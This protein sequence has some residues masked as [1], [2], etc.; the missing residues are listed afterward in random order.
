MNRRHL[1]L[2]AGLALCLLGMGGDRFRYTR[3]VNAAPGANVLELPLDVLSAAAPGLADVRLR[4][5]HGELPLSLEAPAESGQR[6][7]LIDVEAAP[8]RETQA[9]LDRGENPGL[10]SGL[11]LLVE[12]TQAFL[13]PLVVEA[14]DDRQSF[15]VLA[16]TSIFRTEGGSSLE[17][18]F[19][20]SDRRYLRLRF[21][22][23][24]SPPIQPLAAELAPAPRAA[25]PERRLSLAFRA[26]PDEADD[27][28]RYTAVLPGKNLPAVRLELD[29]RGASLAREVRVYERLP[30]RGELSRRL[31]AATAVE[32][33]GAAGVRS[34]A[35]GGLG[36][37]ELELELERAGAPLELA[38][39]TLVWEPVRVVFVAPP[40]SGL[41]LAYGS[42]GAPPATRDAARA[43]APLRDGE[44]FEAT[45]GPVIDHGPQRAFA[46]VERSPLPDAAEY[47][48][49]RA[50]TL[51]AEGELAY[52]DLTGLAP[53]AAASL[54]LLDGSGRQVPFVVEQPARRAR[55]PLRSSV[56]SQ[57][58][59][60]TLTLTGFDP[61]EHVVGLELVTRSPAPFARAVRVYELTRDQRGPTGRRLL[62]SGHWQRASEQAE[63]RLGVSISRPS[64]TEGELVVEIDDGDNAPLASLGGSALVARARIDF[65]FEPGDRL[66][67]LAD[68]PR[69]TPA[70]YDLALLADR[71]QRA[72]ALPA[73]LA[74]LTRA[75]PTE[76]PASERR[77]LW[78]WAVFVAAGALVVLTLTRVLRPDAR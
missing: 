28:D 7:S 9:L 26:A 30:F 49:R 70:R 24:L 23:R 57:P 56:A 48:Q 53:E 20:P 55:V 16:R 27:F 73:T 8:G 69:G 52:L 29:L 76:S 15:R 38:A 78:F 66:T 54:R 37:A 60:T 40:G 58:S 44:A 36:S 11:R 65:V 68:N 22:D 19:P 18:R 42:P 64:T 39:A 71:I 75:P 59:R 34:I 63:P 6:R 77:P 31:L 32:R 67:L 17:V 45:L 3:A 43:S 51:P 4:G 5:K 62:G 14:S 1:C 47:R 21:D 12:G 41:E 25:P 50:I 2:L 10:T 74:P 13:K 72:P 35:L 46:P 61:A 33:D